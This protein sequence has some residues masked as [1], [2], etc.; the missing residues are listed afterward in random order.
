MKISEIQSA[1]RVELNASVTFIVSGQAK[2]SLELIAQVKGRTISEVV[3][4]II[5]GFLSS[6]EDEL[7]TLDQGA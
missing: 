1:P 3:R 4:E 7:K 6:N 2:K 5:D